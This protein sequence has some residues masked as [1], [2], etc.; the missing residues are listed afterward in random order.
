MKPRQNPTYPTLVLRN[1]DTHQPLL[2]IPQPGYYPGYSTMSQRAFWD[3]AT[4]SL[5]EQRLHIPPPVRFFTSDEAAFWQAVFNHILPQDDRTPDRRIPIVPFLDDRLY[6][7]RTV[8]YRFEDM[9]HDR[10]IYKTLGIQAI[11]SEA[12]S[13]FNKPFLQ[14]SHQEQ[15]TVLRTLHDGKPQATPEIWRQMS[16]HRFWQLLTSDAI[17]VYY[18]HPWAWD[19]IG[20]GGPAYPRAYTRLERGEPEPWEVEEERY[21]WLAPSASLSDEVD[22]AS[23]HHTEAEQLRHPH[24]TRSA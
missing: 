13:A 23:H 19:E 4:R 12:Q 5:V 1:P 17:D 20:F 14:L 2:Q 3:K 6:H 8:G 15:E 24:R 11:D 7:N 10:D 22:D 16:V 18:A 21:D 9:P